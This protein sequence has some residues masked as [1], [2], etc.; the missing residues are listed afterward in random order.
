MF[1]FE[2]HNYLRLLLLIPLLLLLGINAF[3][4][5]RRKLARL[6]EKPLIRAMSHRVSAQRR[7]VKF[8]LCLLAV[9]ML[10]LTLA[11]P[12]VGTVVSSDKRSGLEIMVALDISRSMMAEDVSPSRLQ[13]SK[14][15]IEQLINSFVDDKIGLVVFAGDAFVQ[16]PLTMDHVT[17]KMFLQTVNCN[18]V[19]NQGKDI[20]QA[21]DLASRSF[22]SNT[23]IGKVIIL[24][25]DGEDHEGGVEEAIAEAKKRGIHTFVLGVGKTEGAPVPVGG[26]KYLKDENNEHVL[27]ALNEQM[28]KQIAEKGGGKYIHVVSGNAAQKALNHSLSKLQKGEVQDITYDEF[29]EQF[30][31]FAL[32]TFI[33]LAVEMCIREAENLFFRRINLFK[34]KH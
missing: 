15:M 11:R 30:Q 34:R 17:A 13:K 31:L 19:S 6:G 7:R 12:Q 28:C 10:V 29:A 3:R 27:S 4:T 1:R 5:R 21:I 23:A 24:V 14:M 33:L 9:A 22:T 32:F 25:T 18:I 20:A 8:Y 2:E 16:L 26:G